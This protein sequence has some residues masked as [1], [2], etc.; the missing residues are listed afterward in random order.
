MSLH[1][2]LLADLDD[3]DDEAGEAPEEDDGDI[4]MA[5]AAA[6]AEEEL[7]D[8]KVDRVGTIAK[9]WDSDRLRNVLSQIEHYTSN[10]REEAMGPIEEDPEFKL[11]VEANELTQEVD[12]EVTII[13][14]YVRD[15]YAKRFHELESLVLNPVDYIRTVKMLQNNLDMATH[16]MT[17]I[18]APATIMVV[19]VTA[20]TNQGENLSESELERCVEGCDMGLHLLDARKSILEYVESRMHVVAPN[21]T[22]ICGS[23]TA[24][25]LM[26][27]AGGL[28]GLSKMP[29]C[30]IL[31]L[32]S[33]KKALSG[34][35]SA[36]MLPHT[37][38]VFFSDFVQEQPPE[39][40]RKAARLVSAKLALAARVDS[41]G[42]RG[43]EPTTGISLR[44]EI[45]KKIDKAQEPPPAKVPKALPAPDDPVK[46]KRGGRRVRKQKE[47]LAVTEARKL[48]NRMTF[49]EPEED[50]LQEDLGFS[51]GML[52]KAG[53][54]KFRVAQETKQKTGRVSKKLQKELQQKRHGGLSSIRGSS[55]TSSVAF[56][57]AVGLEIINPNAGEQR[58]KQVSDKYFGES[59][60]FAVI[61]RP[62]PE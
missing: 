27:A 15:L 12:N 30:N 59:A 16:D 36:Q 45:E 4:A 8:M 1:D 23:S 13:H 22:Y 32:G 52:G 41:Y 57:P 31:L 9:L 28:T 46:K 43:A 49:G 33:T 6:A 10:P 51:T 61:K 56:T 20:S 37:G 3:L 34:F 42:K 11:I 14:K 48:A 24:A 35:S 26:G 29:A 18:L 62:K 19:S 39:F 50:T 21:L 60:S 5:P 58:A 44:E 54:N 7:I 2:Q 53:S 25:R 55:G 17:E 40:R 47:S 38:F